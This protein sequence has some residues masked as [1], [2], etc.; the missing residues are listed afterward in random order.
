MVR[1]L[2]PSR[3][4]TLRKFTLWFDQL[5]EERGNHREV[6][7]GA[8]KLAMNKLVLQASIALSEVVLIPLRKVIL[9]DAGT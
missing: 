5:T 6:V 8:G 7:V 2:G 9:L 3:R 1:N 4:K